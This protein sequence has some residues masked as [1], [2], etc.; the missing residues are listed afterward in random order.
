MLLKIPALGVSCSPSLASQPEAEL[1]SPLGRGPVETEGCVGPVA[2][3]SSAC[4]HPEQG[5]GAP[6]FIQALL[7]SHL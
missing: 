4:F 5:V 1:C 7:P 6:A 3:T 2:L